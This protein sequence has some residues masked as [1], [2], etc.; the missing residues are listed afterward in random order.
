MGGLFVLLIA[1]VN[2]TNLNTALSMSRVKEM[3]VRQVLG[4]SKTNLILLTLMESV[5]YSLFALA[6]G[7]IMASLLF[8][9]FTQLTGIELLPPLQYF[10]PGLVLISILCGV[11]AGL[12]PSMMMRTVHALEAMKHNNNWS[13]K[14][15]GSTVAMRRIMITVQFCATIILIASAF[16]GYRQFNF[17]NQ[18]NLGLNAEQIIA[19]PTIPNMVSENYIKLKNNLKT[20]SGIS[21]VT[22][23]MQVPS[24][25]IK[26]V[27]PV[28][29]K[30]VNEDP[31][32]APMMDIQIVDPDFMKMMDLTLLEG[33]DA[34]AQV[35]LTPHPATNDNYTISDYLLETNRKYIINETAMKQ[36]GWQNPSD[37]IG[38]EINWTIGNL[39]LAYGPISGVVKDFHQETL[40][41]KVDP[42]IMT[43]EPIWLSNILIQVQT[44]QVSQTIREI[45]NVWNELFPFAM[46]YYFLDELY[47]RL[48]Q[49]DSV[50]LKLLSTLSLI[51]I[52]ISF[53]GLVS[54][55]AFAL[56]T[57]SK[58]LAIRRVV[59]ANLLELTKL[60]GKEY[61]WII[62]VAAIIG[63][64]ISYYWVGQWLQNFAY[65]IDI[66]F[67]I[68][69][70][71][72]V[73]IYLLLTA[74]I[75]LQTLRATSENPVEALREE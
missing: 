15:S 69:L 23:C 55:M 73:L 75:Y 50:Q 24:S 18:K 68:Y 32:Q 46:E 45:E 8:P 61:I 72:L 17:I 47:N 16:I 35:K 30:G 39:E 11:I 29:I 51:A 63:I 64:P 60:L 21:E 48:Y 58:E 53:L 62:G 5:I 2:F 70:V 1:L 67:G 20:I 52:F 13:M 66:S 33:E 26:D 28:L 34:L 37:A 71:A 12:F 9:A 44:A 10:I 25:E 74:T 4:A 41:N 19:L 38:H 42:L 3:G 56:K 65:H 43:V 54:L 7:A 59:G 49:Q 36:L 31:T 22:A 6:L 40:K 27:G 57:R 14:N